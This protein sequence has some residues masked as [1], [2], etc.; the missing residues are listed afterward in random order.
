MGNLL[1]ET[2]NLLKDK[3]KSGQD[4]IWVSGN[5]FHFSWEDF[6]KV[7]KDCD[8]GNELGGQ[9]VALDLIVVGKDFWLER[10]EYNGSEWWEFKAFPV[11]PN[12]YKTPRQLTGYFWL[13][14][15]EINNLEESF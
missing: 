9:E 7:A 3:G 13:S 11:K 10:H 12:R 1:E 14:L 15:E 8:Y 6:E 2:L 5:D 4:V